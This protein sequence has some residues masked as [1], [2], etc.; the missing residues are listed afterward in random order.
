MSAPIQ[1]E[2]Y[3]L[4]LA[5]QAVPLVMD[6]PHSSSTFPQDFNACL[7]LEDLRDGEDVFIDA[8]WSHAPQ[9]G[10]HL[11]LAEFARTYIDPNRHVGDVDLS[12]IDGE[13]PHTYVPSGKANIGKSL[14][15]RT[16]DDGRPIYDR[17]LS[18][19]EVH[20]RIQRYAL[21]YQA[22]LQKLI[23]T[24]HQ[25]FGVCYHINCHSMSAVSGKMGEGGP[26]IARA[27]V[28]LGDRDGTTCNAEFTHL[29]KDFMQG[30][31]YAVKINDPFK[32]VELVRAFSNPA[33]GKHSLQIELNKRLYTDATGRGK[34]A[35][36]DKLAQDLQQLT[37]VLAQFAK[38]KA[39]K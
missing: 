17:K 19:D 14:I 2:A 28:V 11:L 8:L 30:C 23:D 9:H 1:T 37:A 18:I 3:S 36:Y 4:F 20:Q 38:S 7:P 27:D 15:W 26:G 32:G 34:G 39:A 13:W 6:S 24:H 5:Q 29:V 12:M 22:Q 16:L 35:N 21:P 33:Q 25:T 10:A 31:G